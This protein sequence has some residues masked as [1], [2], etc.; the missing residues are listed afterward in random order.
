MH[1][2]KGLRGPLRGR[3]AAVNRGHPFRPENTVGW[4]GEPGISSQGGA[5]RRLPIAK[6]IRGSLGRNFNPD[7]RD[8]LAIRD[9]VQ[10]HRKG[11]L[12]VDAIL[13]LAAPTGFTEITRF[14]RHGAKCGRDLVAV[15]VSVPAIEMALSNCSA[16]IS[17]L[18]QSAS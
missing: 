13:R 6:T 17:S 15:L 4:R 3:R 2:A 9:R 16:A 1:T 10:S 7:L 11:E 18:I 14:R 5:R 8:E 12:L